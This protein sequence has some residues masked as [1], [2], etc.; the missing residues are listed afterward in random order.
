MSV[1]PIR[2]SLVE[3]NEH[4]ACRLQQVVARGTARD[5]EMAHE[6]SL[7][8]ALRRLSLEHFDAVL[9]DLTLADGSALDALTRI[10]ETA[11]DVPI[12]VLT[13]M[14]DE[15]LAVRALKAGAQDSLVKGQIDGNLLVRA[16]RYAIER[17]QLQMALHAMSL[18]DELTGLYNRRGF[19]TLARQQLKMADRLRKRVSHIFVDLDGLKRINDTMGHRARRSGAHRDGGDA[20][21]DVPRLRH[22]RAH[23][24]RRVR[25]ARHGQRRG[26]ARGHVAARVQENIA[27]A[28]AGRTAPTR[29]R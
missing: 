28:I 2:C 24:R 27:S 14:E 25:G 10:G 8:D 5:V 18:I 12:I 6:R 13:S 21:G 1:G 22:H 29:C 4:E 26:P 16:I 20:E 11:P 23:R 7:T 19:L 9:V 17:H 15:T 3:D